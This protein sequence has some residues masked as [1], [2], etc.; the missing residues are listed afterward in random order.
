LNRFRNRRQQFALWL[1][2]AAVFYRALIPAGFMPGTMQQA[3][4][5]AVLVLCSGGALKAADRQP[6]APHFYVNCDFAAAAASAPPPELAPIALPAF[7]PVP[8]PAVALRRSGLNQPA[9]PPPA[10]G[11]PLYS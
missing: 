4:D 3:R 2:L 1:A 10:R 5:G 11:P 9:L 7:A 6:A 8:P